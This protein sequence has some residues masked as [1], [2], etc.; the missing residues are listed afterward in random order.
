MLIHVKYDQARYARTHA[1][2]LIEALIAITILALTI[3]GIVY[4]YAQ[5]ERVAIWSSMSAAAQSYALQGLEQARSAEWN[6]WDFNTNGAYSEDQ[7]GCPYTNIQSDLLD[8][9]IKG[10]P[11]ASNNDYFATNYVFVTLVTNSSGGAQYQAALRQIT[12]I[13]YWTDPYTGRSFS[14]VVVSLRASDQ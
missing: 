11:S 5:V 10:N 2:S 1:F 4:G 6:A 12:S 9:P 8:I 14:N 13:C 3:G 7:T